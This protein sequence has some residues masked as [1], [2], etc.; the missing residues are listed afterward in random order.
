MCNTQYVP[1]T[2]ISYSL[3]PTPMRIPDSIAFDHYT[4]IKH[5]PQEPLDLPHQSCH[6]ELQP[7]HLWSY[8]GLA[9]KTWSY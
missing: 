1:Y 3:G 2:A 5:D 9:C 6:K 7:A 4:F 8:R